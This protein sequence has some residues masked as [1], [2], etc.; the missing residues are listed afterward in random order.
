MNLRLLRPERSALPGCATP[1]GRSTAHGGQTDHN[2]KTYGQTRP[3]GKSGPQIRPGGPVAIAGGI[4]SL[5]S[6]SANSARI[7]DRGSGR[8]Q[9]PCGGGW[10]GGDSPGLAGFCPEAIGGTSFWDWPVLARRSSEIG[11]A[12]IPAGFAI[13]TGLQALALAAGLYFYTNRVFARKTAS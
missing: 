7:A 6:V 1:R 2:F 9:A 5:R 12:G 4:A 8:V 10:C 3:C 11:V 13:G